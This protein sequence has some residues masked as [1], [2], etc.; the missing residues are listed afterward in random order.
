MI[1][2][3][4]R[5]IT[6]TPGQGN[7]F[8]P[9]CESNQDYAIKRV[10]RFF[11]LYFIPLIP[12]DKLG[13]Y[14]ECRHCKDTYKLDVLAYSPDGNDSVIEAE[15]FEVIKKAMIHVLLAD[16]VIE[17]SELA[18]ALLVYQKVTG[19]TLTEDMLRKEIDT[20]QSNR[21]DLSKYL[22]GVQE[23]LTHDAKILILRAAYLI[24]MAD[25]SFPTEEELLVRQIGK[26][27]AI[28]K[29]TIDEILR[30]E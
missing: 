25:E 10:R 21:E 24:A 20:I 22:T 30:E 28:H 11:T 1:I 2:F 7:F 8:C 18:V 14:V 15:Y 27:L 4:T 9:S 5:G 23:R 19:K 29:D 3:G 12:L 17:D 13:E 26:D 6:T 16:G